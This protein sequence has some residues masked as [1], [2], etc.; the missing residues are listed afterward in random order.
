MNCNPLIQRTSDGFPTLKIEP[1]FDAVRGKR[2]EVCGMSAKHLARRWAARKKPLLRLR[3]DA[4][5]AA[6]KGDG[7]ADVVEGADPGDHSFNA[8]AEAGVG[9]RA[10]AA[11]VEVPL[12]GFFGQLVL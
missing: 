10:V 4:V 9:D 1:P 11:Q 8:H 12:E 7:L 6:G 5:Q 3:V 2:R